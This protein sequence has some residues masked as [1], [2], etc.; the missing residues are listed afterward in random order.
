AAKYSP[1]RARSSPRA[2]SVETDLDGST[3]DPDLV[4]PGLDGEVEVVLARPRVVF[5]PVPGTGQVVVRVEPALAERPLQVQAVA[6]QREEL[7][8]QVHERD[9][10]LARLDGRDGAGRNVLDLG[11]GH[12]LH[13]LDANRV[14]PSGRR[15]DHP[16]GG[17]GPLHPGE[18]RGVAPRTP[19]RDDRQ[20]RPA[21]S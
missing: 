12:E 14:L 18:A 17:G 5:P 10:L 19:P 16:A 1:L 11:D 7:A 4:G 2:R 9:R 21:G 3:L 13:G 6:L 15:G 20:R 8:V